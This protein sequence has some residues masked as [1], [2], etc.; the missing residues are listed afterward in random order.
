MTTRHDDRELATALLG[1]ASS[2]LVRTVDGLE[3][4]DWSAPSLLPGWSRAH[5]VAHLALNAEGIARA[6]G[7]VVADDG[8]DGPRAMYDSDERRDSD[9][10]ELAGSD[11]AVLRERLL[12]GTTTLNDAIAA[13]PD[14]AWETTLERTPGGRRIRAASFP[15]MRLREIEI[16]HVDLGAS[17]TRADWAPAV[18][19]NLLDAMT[20]RDPGE[21]GSFEIRPLDL[22]RTWVIGG[23]VGDTE[24]EYPV[25]V[26]TGPASDIA[27]W[28][29][30]RPTPETLSCSHGELPRIEGW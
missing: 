7:G 6:L 23:V 4:D 12:A 25:P 19:E 13:I 16:H 17:Y 29:T 28:L 2:R 1:E 18:A 9:I 24:A 26:V 11:P 27:W 14:D 21:G 30:G 22:E 8:D 3:D 5:V 10:A 15:G 20:R